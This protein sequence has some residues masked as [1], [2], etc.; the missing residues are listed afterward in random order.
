MAAA[1]AAA[2]QLS[3]PTSQPSPIGYGGYSTSQESKEADM[4][5]S[6]PGIGAFSPMTAAYSAGL[7]NYYGSSSSAFHPSTGMQSASA[8]SSPSAMSNLL[9]PGSQVSS[10]ASGQYHPSV[11]AADYRRPLQVIF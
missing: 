6:S 5:R 11:N 4:K 8:S 9:Q 10:Y 3:T 7:G 2:A 1:A